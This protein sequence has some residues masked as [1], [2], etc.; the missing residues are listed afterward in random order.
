MPDTTPNDIPS[1]CVLMNTASPE[2]LSVPTFGENNSGVCADTTGESVSTS[3][4][5]LD[6][7]PK[8][9]AANINDLNNNASPYNTKGSGH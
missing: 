7:Q 8:D 6:T 2:I 5:L 9:I 1:S 3:C 4:S